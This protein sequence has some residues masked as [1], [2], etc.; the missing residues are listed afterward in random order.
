MR[1]RSK[2]DVSAA[3]R[4]AFLVFYEDTNARIYGWLLARCGNVELAQD[5]VADAYLDTL[6][7]FRT[8]GDEVPSTS[9]LFTIAK[10]RL[11]DH[12]RRRT[13]AEEKL[14]LIVI[15]AA[16]NSTLDDADERILEALNAL[17]ERQ[18]AAVALRYLEGFGVNEIAD[19][20]NV[21]YKS[22]ESLLSRGRQT[23]RTCYETEAD[24]G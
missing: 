23:L 3:Q 14:Q 7:A 21:S 18:R 20:L 24:R 10:R 12:W 22:A 19:Q 4:A 2:D 15:D 17:P 6:R 8:S 11:V 16:A 9:L 1:S 13:T 5:L